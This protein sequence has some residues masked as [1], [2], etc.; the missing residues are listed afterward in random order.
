MAAILVFDPRRSA[1]C[2][3]V[4]RRC[5]MRLA[6][7]GWCSTGSEH[8]QQE[9]M[10][11][12]TVCRRRRKLTIVRKTGRPKPLHAV[13]RCMKRM[14]RGVEGFR[15]RIVRRASA[16]NSRRSSTNADDA[17]QAAIAMQRRVADLPPVS[18]VQLAIRVGFH[19]GPVREDGGSAPW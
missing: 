6:S 16:T 17:C 12:G 3:P 5:C 4:V 8:E 7:R 9:E 1:K 13:E 15:G 18:G 14:A 11:F 19:H 2:C 10:L